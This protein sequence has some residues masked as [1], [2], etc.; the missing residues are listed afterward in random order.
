MTLSL[1]EI[2]ALAQDCLTRAGVRPAVARLVAAEVAAAEA[3]DE[4]VHGLHALLRD[5][6]LIRYG[7]LKPSATASLAQPWPGLMTA[8]AGHGFATAALMHALPRLDSRV[9]SQG[10]M[11]LRLDQA[12]PPGALI[13][14][15]QSLAQQGLC[16]IGRGAGLK[17]RVAHP[18]A[19]APRRFSGD[20]QNAMEAMLTPFVT[21][22]ATPFHGP[23]AHQA[24]IIAWLP[25]VNGGASPSDFL[26]LAPPTE[27][28]NPV[29]FSSELL[30]ELVAA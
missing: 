24:W 27:P 15:L 23:V 5:L 17:G 21:D 20:G 1:D 13:T 16:A 19:P 8:D 29:T 10:V 30:E 4:G 26:D 11:M 9:R 28:I 7:H 12:S 6:R 22:T 2:E 18:E 14:P 25:E 3:A